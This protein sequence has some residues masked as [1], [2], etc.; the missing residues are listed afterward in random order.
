MHGLI[1]ADINIV[2]MMDNNLNIGSSDIIPV[3]LKN[4]GSIKTVI[5]YNAPKDLTVVK[6]SKQD[7]T[8]KEELPGATLIIKDSK[9]KEIDKWVS[10]DEPH[11][12]KGLK[13]GGV[14]KAILYRNEY[15]I[16]RLD[17]VYKPGA[18]EK[19][20]PSEDEVRKFIENRKQKYTLYSRR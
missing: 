8:T 7:I 18:K 12:I 14:S 13:E 16:F 20:L 3:Q 4:D 9:G 6:I 5:M 11:V 19:E 17:K 2:K 1:V 15:Y 10:G